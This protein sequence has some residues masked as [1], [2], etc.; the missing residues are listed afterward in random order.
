V[1]ATRSLFGQTF[2][3]GAIEAY[4][5]QETGSRR[6]NRA[7]KAGLVPSVLY[8]RRADGTDAEPQLLFLEERDVAREIRKRGK[9]LENTLFDLTI[10]GETVR[11]LPRQLEMHPCAFCRCAHGGVQLRRLTVLGSRSQ[12]NR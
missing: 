8:G 2:D 10:N 11:V 4:P 3:V 12:S 9:T 5:R 6:M 1:G 7:R